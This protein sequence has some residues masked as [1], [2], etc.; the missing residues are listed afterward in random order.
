MQQPKLKTF[1]HMK[2][3]F[4][5]LVMLFPVISSFSQ[6]F[7]VIIADGD[8]LMKNEKYYEAYKKYD[9]A[10]AADSRRKNEAK[11]KRDEL[12]QKIETLR[13]EAV[14]AKLEAQAQK[15]IADAALAQAK[16]FIN[17]LDLSDNNLAL[18]YKKGKIGYI[19]KKGDVVIEYLYETAG[20]FD[21]TGFAKVQTIEEFAIPNTLG[22]KTE[23]KAVDYLIDL[24]NNQ[25]KVA[26]RFEDIKTEEEI[27][28]TIKIKALDLRNSRLN[29]FPPQ[30]LDQ[31][32]LEILILDAGLKQENNFN[33]IPREIGNF[34][35]LKYFSASKCKIETIPTEI[36]QLTGLQTLNLQ[37]NSMELLPSGIT[38][39]KELQNLNLKE[40][41]LATLPEGIGQLK[42]LEVLLLTHNP[43]KSLPPDFIELKSLK[44]LDLRKSSLPGWPAGLEKIKTLRELNFSDNSLKTFPIEILQLTNLEILE[45][46]SNPITS[47]PF[48]IKRLTELKFLRLRNNELIDLMPDF[49]LPAK[50]KELD[51]SGNNLTRFP[52]QILKLT[53]LE[54]LDMSFN[55]SLK[56]IPP[57]ISQLK[58]LTTLK[59][60]NTAIPD[61]ERQKIKNM[62]PW[63]N[64]IF[65]Q[66]SN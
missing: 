28:D 61:S 47:L 10:E 31:P 37:N 49:E 25:Y 56:S 36:G 45:I 30:I 24:K 52:L 6:N 13:K 40:N 2:N 35:N 48:N 59:L 50:L 66:T 33:A 17:V 46:S 43:I 34:Q 4:I 44:V 29:S 20:A 16:K 51:L 22:V 11:L 23:Y 53:D 32:Q 15:G 27:I 12:F 14:N 64:I 21:N 26:Y 5:F 54:S 63:C 19:N 9:A 60:N 18:A 62:V 65:M 41:N 7:D 42:K 58:K 8:K 55:K 39:L 1:T 57:Q 3:V 38:R